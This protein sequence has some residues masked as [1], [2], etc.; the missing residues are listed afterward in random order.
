MRV[1]SPARL[2]SI[3]I[4]AV[5]VR[6]AM[7]VR[8]LVAAW[9]RAGGGEIRVEPARWRLKTPEHSMPKIIVIA[10]KPSL[11]RAIR[12]ALTG[13]QWADYTITSAFGH[14]YEQAEPDDYL[15]DSLPRTKAGKKVWRRE[16]L[17]IVPVQW[18]RN[19]KPGA[20]QQISKIKGLLKGASLVVN[21][22]D[23]DREGQLL[24][25]E[26]VEELG[27]AGPV[28]RVWFTSLA[29]QTIRAAFE[30]WKD[31]AEYRPLSQAAL[32]RSRADWLVGMNLT[33]AF[34][35]ASK[36]LVSIGRVQT[37]TLALVVRRDLAIDS[38]I[39]RDY[40][41]VLGTFEHA[42]GTF[43]AKWKPR[44]TEGPGFD[45]EGRLVDKAMADLVAYAARQEGSAVLSSYSAEKKSRAAPLPFSLSALQK[46]ASAKLGLSAK[47][48]LD[49]AQS[50]Y[51]AKL[52]TYPRTD[53]QYLSDDQHAEL[54]A[55]AKELAAAYKIEVS[56][57]KHAA[58]NS[59]KISAHTAI[60][61][62]GQDASRLRGMEAQLF[63]L[64]ARSA[65]ALFAAPEEY[66]A[67]RAGVDAGGERFEAAGKRVLFPGWTALYSRQADDETEATVPDM[68][69][70]DVLT[71]QAVDVRAQKTKAPAHFTE[72]TLIEA[73]SNVH[74]FVE[75][76]AAKAKLRETSGIGT[77]ATRASILETL[78]S[79]GWIE[80][81]SKAVVSTPS[82]RAVV[83]GLPAELTDP[84]ITARWEDYLSAIAAGKLEAP[85]FEAAI[86]DFVRARVEGAKAISGLPAQA[87][88]PSK[89]SVGPG[90]GGRSNA[91]KF[92]VR[93]SSRKAA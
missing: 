29:P 80:R 31:N 39:P 70:G 84:V 90:G 48:T 53:C 51:E 71:V 52:T 91:R 42:A 75:D 6:Y 87:V 28:K 19:P 11:A 24:V 65:I 73:M 25:D 60:V 76:E 16:D 41:D 7:R 38:F 68:H 34:T 4:P 56:R 69:E 49:I 47:Q 20:A 12:E 3:D 5:L 63:D 22:G 17:P 40:F 21:A 35:L 45:E 32:A 83:Q 55:V 93:K 61:P 89:G 82:G 43:S 30:H 15:P 66:L 78:F 33:R 13:P 79:R 74:R 57:M 64:V 67:I 59:A 37:P 27:Y 23:A 54:F 9:H 58:F 8:S 46:A 1:H 77:E 81:K 92:P 88:K 44:G 14:I 2:S 26:I 86:V 50:L 10:E 62:T 72:G 36:N 18:L 85:K